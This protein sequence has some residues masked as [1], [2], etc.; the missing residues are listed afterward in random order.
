MLHAARLPAAR[1]PAAAGASR[2]PSRA[3]TAPL[4]THDGSGDS[5][6]EIR[7]KKGEQGITEN[8]G[9]GV[10]EGGVA[11]GYASAGTNENDDTARDE[12]TDAPADAAAAPQVGWDSR[13]VL[14]S[15]GRLGSFLG[16]CR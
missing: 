2:C 7:L 1:P 14:Q 8:D 13:R 11:V 10:V 5:Q 4:P 3:L 9:F 6:P 16:A 15:C 12:Q